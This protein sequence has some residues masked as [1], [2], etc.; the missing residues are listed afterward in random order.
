MTTDT[1]PKEISVETEL[2]NGKKVKLV[3]Y[4]KRIWNDRTLIWVQCYPFITTDLNAT[5][6]ELK[7][8]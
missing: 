1:F 4:D 8:A 6:E 7:I 2:K 3:A 5:P